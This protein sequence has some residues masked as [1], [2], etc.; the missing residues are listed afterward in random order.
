MLN[1]LYVLIYLNKQWI[2]CGLLEYQEEGRRSSSIFRYGKKYLSRREAISID[3]V[4]LPLE[5]RNF[6]TPQGFQMFNGIRDAS[7]DKWGRYL[8]DKKFSR[9]LSEIEYIASSSE[10][11]AGALGFS[12]FLG[13]ENPKQYE[14]N[15]KFVPSSTKKRLDL[16]QCSG[17]IEDVVAS[18]E[19]ERLKQYLDYGPSLGGARPKSTV[20]WKNKLYLAKFSLSLDSKNEPL[21]EYATMTLAKKCGLNVPPLH[22][23]KMDG[24][25]I[26]LIQRFDREKTSPLPFVSGLTITGLHENDFGAWSYFSI[27]DAIIRFAQNP[28][29]EL[30][31]LF[32]R[33]IFNITVY[34]NDDHPRNFG[35]L[36]SGNYWNLSPLYDVSPAVIHTNTYTLAMAFGTEGRRASY[37]NALSLCERFRI[38][39]TQARHTIHEIQELT[40]TWKK[41]F[42]NV[43]VP[44]SDIK[45]LENSFEGKE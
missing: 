8:L 27:A 17:A 10:D 37:R 31:E 7:P 9:T 32:R 4:Q 21:I 2:P 42:Q 41:H 14:P 25:F 40:S 23:E 6:E 19:T 39:K 29:K 33:L 38:S 24:R 28:E 12:N 44:K 16:T 18:E 15:G 11:R 3:P 45:M 35:F 22:L 20:V 1:R 34:N 36:R 26:F 13:T 43:G 30:K 5:D